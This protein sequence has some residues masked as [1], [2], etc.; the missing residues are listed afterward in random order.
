[1]FYNYTFFPLIVFRISFRLDL[2]LEFFLK[3]PIL[4]LCF[5]FPRFFHHEEIAYIGDD[6]NDTKLLSSVGLS[7]APNDGIFTLKTWGI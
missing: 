3:I 7:A 1:M 5:D 2:L 6:V 4:I